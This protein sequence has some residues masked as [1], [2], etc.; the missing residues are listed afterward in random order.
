MDDILN[1]YE[2]IHRQITDRSQGHVF[3]FW[4]QLDDEQRKGLLEE[5]D[6]LDLD[7]V[8]RLAKEHLG[9][10]EEASMP[11]LEPAPYIRLPRTEAELEEH[12]EAQRVGEAALR[13]GR[14]AAAVVA[15]GQGT[16][17]GYDGP[18][19]CY[20][21]GPVSGKSL[22]QLFAEKILAARRRY[23]A[24]VSW[25]VM[26]SRDNDAVTREFFEANRFF[27]LPPEDVFFFQQGQMPALDAKGR[28][29]MSSPHTLAMSPDGH[30]GIIRA[31]KRRGALDDMARRGV[32]YISHFQV[33]NV[34]VPPVDPLF[35]GFHIE[36]SSQMSSRMVK[37]RSPEERVGHFCL[38]DGK[39]QVVE[40]SDMPGELA[41]KRRPNGEL[42]FDAGNIA[43]HVYDVEFV[44][45]LNQRG[46]ELPFHRAWKKVPYVN[47]LSHRIRPGH[48]NANKFE[49]FVFDAL[50]AAERTIVL[51][52][53]REEIF[54][55][56]K[57]ARGEDSV[58]SAR[59]D[60][61]RQA[62]RW[63][64]AAG[65]DIDVDETGRPRHKLEVSPLFA[66]DPAMFAQSAAER[67]ITRIDRDT[68]LA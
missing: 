7:E 68:Y 65:V 58:P 40:Y 5:L 13:E 51:E 1:G 60:L 16:R 50:P 62:A 27:G 37:K 47:E 42:V 59:D 25:Y 36:R 55:P 17:L 12:R 43:V 18:K 38:V 53:A 2:R 3:R 54:S 39:L 35:V 63:A 61:M 24:P 9:Q 66:L 26:T 64:R 4:D 29:L 34:L 46:Y 67:G 33:D 45:Q 41:E 8:D 22:F 52:A 32:K 28:L 23:E 11:Y 44:D 21:I 6:A 15:G 20:P 30:G 48:P 56:V 57:N 31:L 10:E 19:G 14:V 49:M